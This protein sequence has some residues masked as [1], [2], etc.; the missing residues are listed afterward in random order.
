MPSKRFTKSLWTDEQVMEM[1]RLH[2]LGVNQTQLAEQFG[3]SQR[4]VSRAL[5]G[6]SYKH[7]PDPLKPLEG[8]R[9]RRK[10]APEVA[11]FIRLQ[12]SA[13][14]PV[15]LER[16]G[17]AYGVHLESIRKIIRGD[18]YTEVPDVGARVNASG[19]NGRMLTDEQVIEARRRYRTRWVS[20]AVLAKEYGVS[21]KPMMN[22]LRGHSYKELPHAVPL[23]IKSINRGYKITRRKRRESQSI[24]S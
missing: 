5:L 14:T 8:L 13:S 16:L 3:G 20:V 2:R 17:K 7:V 18:L 23:H 15:S 10:L 12:Y 11:L 1:R 21:V 24:A 6:I 22:L 9:V 4:I 19:P